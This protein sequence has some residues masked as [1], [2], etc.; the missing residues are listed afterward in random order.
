LPVEGHVTERP[1]PDPNVKVPPAVKAAADRAEALMT[2]QREAKAAASS[3][4]ESRINPPS[5]KPAQVLTADFDPN[6][7]KP[8]GP[9][10][11]PLFKPSQAPPQPAP[12]PMPDAPQV[13]QPSPADLEHQFNSLRGRYSKAEEDNRRMA[14]QIQDM[15]RLFASLQTAP[16][17][18]VPQ[19]GQGQEGSGVR[20]SGPITG[21][22]RYIQPK[23]QAEY[24]DELLDVMGRA[25]MDR[26]EAPLAQLQAELAGI[27]RQLGG[28]QRTVVYDAQEKMYQQLKQEVPH[29][30]QINEHPEFH[31][32]LNMPDPMSGQIRQNLLSEAY[33]RNEA[34]R[35]AHVFKAFLADQA[36]YVPQ[37]GQGQAPGNGAGYIPAPTPQFDL[38]QYAAPGRAKPG[39][40]QVGSPEK[41][42]INAAE[43]KQFYSD[44][45]N[46][47][48]A[49]READY[50]AIQQQIMDAMRENRIR[51]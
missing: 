10:D 6:N 26:V 32:W 36:P 39:Q 45:A 37:N 35:V 38:A 40:T 47:K 25:A 43:I 21:G 4:P 42:I 18:S 30:S 20:F 8:P 15:Q 41:P 51:R 9:N 49:G 48:Y 11:L 28:V 17:A 22:R 31:R 34:S 19:G 2:Q 13:P 27:K 12:Q 7:P 3:T 50:N 44:S 5:N 16:V 29:W 23:E 14:A 46:G 33:G 24:G 1:K